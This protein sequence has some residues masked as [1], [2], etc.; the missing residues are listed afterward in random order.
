MTDQERQ[1]LHWHLHRAQ[2]ADHAAMGER[3][4]VCPEPIPDVASPPFES[5]TEAR[6]WLAA[7]RRNLVR[8]VALAH[9]RGW[10]FETWALAEAMWAYFT[11]NGNYDD[12]ERCYELAAAAAEAEGHRVAQIRMLLL[13]G[14]TLTDARSFAEAARILEQARNLADNGID[15]PDP[16]L[17][18]RMLVL[19][20][21]GLEFTGRL[22]LKLE[23]IEQ[24]RDWFDRALSNAL[25][26]DR[27]TDGGN[28]RVIG[29]QLWFLA[30]CHRALGDAVQATDYFD[31]ARERLLQADDSRTGLMVRIDAM[32]YSLELDEPGA[33][34]QVRDALGLAEEQEL[35]LPA[36]E[37][38]HRFALLGPEHQR[39]E[40]LQR[41]LELYR[42]IRDPAADEVRKLLETD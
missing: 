17:A 9:E 34:D 25:E 38:W 40:S 42:A 37:G 20:G 7:N 26:Q 28:P 16:E 29:L 6:L 19:A 23:Q 36:A 32:L 30:Q 1:V 2:L 35:T 27:R 13:L 18:A 22:F 10:H 39:T 41:A 33:A 8:L 15:D 5:K 12:A 3:Y 4:R 11:S 14:Q 24:A 31:D 21:T